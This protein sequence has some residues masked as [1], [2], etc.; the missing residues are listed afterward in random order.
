MFNEN[1]MPCK[2]TDH[3][4]TNV[5]NTK[6]SR[7]IEL[8]HE[9]ETKDENQDEDFLVGDKTRAYDSPISDQVHTGPCE[10][11]S[12]EEPAVRYSAGSN[13]RRSAAPGYLLARDMAKN[14]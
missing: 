3:A 6:D 9:K 10:G 12:V 1:I 13:Q 7:K 8:L 11:D 4:G 5:K 2:V 14:N